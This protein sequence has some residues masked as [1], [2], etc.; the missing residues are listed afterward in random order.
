MSL[1]GVSV[2]TAWYRLANT[3]IDE[4]YIMWKN[5]SVLHVRD[6]IIN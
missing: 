2:P 6:D 4:Y 3:M 5:V 1:F